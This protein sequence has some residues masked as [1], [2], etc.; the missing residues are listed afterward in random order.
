MIKRIAALAMML[1]LFALPAW[2]DTITLNIANGPLYIEDDTH[3]YVLTGTAD[4]VKKV[5]SFGPG[6]FNVTL[7]NLTV[8]MMDQTD[9]P[10]DD[11]DYKS[12]AFSM[13]SGTT[14]YLTLTGENK[15]VGGY[16][17]A[18]LEVMLGAKL[19]ITEQSTGVL[20]AESRWGAAI[21]SSHILYSGGNPTEIQNGEII[22]NGGT[23]YASSG[24]SFYSAY[25]AGIGGARDTAGGN[26][27]INGGT[28]TT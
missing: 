20:R 7:E 6:T 9:S 25:G 14:V 18:G 17:Y 16:Y 13:P 3:D 23:I 4:S 5:I 22:I 15:L 8:D 27:T 10:S 21:G 11:R 12:A 1:C 26:I 28:V 24:R 19:V 2:A